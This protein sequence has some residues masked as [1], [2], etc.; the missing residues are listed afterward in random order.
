MAMDASDWEIRIEG[1]PVFLF[2]DTGNDHLYLVLA[3][4]DDQEWVLRGYPSGT[5]GTGH[6][7]VEDSVPMADSLDFRAFE[8]RDLVGSRVL[9][10]DGRDAQSVWEVMR[11]HARAME[12]AEVPYSVF[13]MNSNSA[14]ASMLHVV[15]IPIAEVLPDQLDRDDNYPGIASIVD[16][17][18]F[19]LTGGDHEDRLL[20]GRQNDR[21]SGGQ[22]DDVLAGQAGSDQLSGGADDDF[23][24]GGWGGLDRLSGGAGADRFYHAGQAGHGSDWIE[25]LNPVDGDRLV[26]GAAADADQ[27]VLRY[28]VTPEAGDAATAEAFVSWRP[29][30]QILWAITDGAALDALVIRADGQD[31]DLLG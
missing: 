28:A 6:I 7:I 23:L 12:D 13:S 8:D 20:G 25:D 2:G 5:F 15:G 27:F 4:P 31:F 22:G 19:V 11:Q 16:A 30:G 17:F 3:S 14:V 1:Q 9:D 21:L 26:F 18:D 10:L 24:N 29:T